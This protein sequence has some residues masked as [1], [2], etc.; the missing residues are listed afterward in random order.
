[1][2]N[3]QKIAHATIEVQ[4]YALFHFY[5]INR[6]NLNRN[7]I[8][9]FKPAERRVQKD[10]AYTHEQILHLL[11]SSSDLRK[12]A[13]VLLLA[14]TG[15]RID[16]L[17]RMTISALSKVNVEGYKDYLYKITVYEGEREQYYCFCS[18]ECTRVLDQYLAYRERS[19]EVLK[20]SSPLIREQFDCNDSFKVTRPKFLS[21][22]TLYVMMDNMLWRSGLRTRTKREDKVRHDVMRYHGLRK[23]AITQ[24]IKA[25]VDFSARSY[26]VGSSVA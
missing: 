14:S 3:V 5:S 17:P 8:S 1:M 23:L 19:G 21:L 20:P 9:K 2:I 13:I 26:L 6:V 12:R 25:K 18:F 22:I 24:M 4:L 15:M 16:A 7:Y 11:A 10:V